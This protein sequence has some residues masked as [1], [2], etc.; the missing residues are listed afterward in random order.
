MSDHLLSP[1]R[2]ENCRLPKH[3]KFV[4]S[5]GFKILLEKVSQ[6][7]STRLR[8]TSENFRLKNEKNMNVRIR[9]DVLLEFESHMW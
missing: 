2:L 9:M 7:L 1:E 6:S 5:T 4:F 8:F 3:E